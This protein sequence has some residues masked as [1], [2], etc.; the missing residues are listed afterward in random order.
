MFVFL[1]MWQSSGMGSQ[2]LW[3][4]FPEPVLIG[5]GAKVN[6]LINSG[7]WWRF[8]T[9]MFIHVNLPHLLINMYSLWMVGPYV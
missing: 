5:Y 8:V 2:V 3:E 1:L 4:G 6:A 9:P 7:E